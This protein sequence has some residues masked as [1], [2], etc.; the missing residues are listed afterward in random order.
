MNP[1]YREMI[2]GGELTPVSKLSAAFLSPRSALHLQF[3]YYESSLVVEFLVERFGFEALK[4]ILKDLREGVSIN[5][6]LARHTLNLQELDDRFD[7]FARTRAEQMAPGLDWTRPNDDGDALSRVFD[8]AALS[9]ALIE[10]SKTNSAAKSTN[11]SPGPRPNFYQLMEAAQTQLEAKQFEQAKGPLGQL[12]ELYP[13]QTGGD[14]AY[15]LLAAAHR[16]LGETK[17]ERE[18]L[19]KLAAQ[20]DSAREVYHRL[21]EL[22]AKDGDWPAVVQ[23]AQR[24]LAVNPLVPPP[25]RFLAQAAEETRNPMAAIRAYRALLQLD[26]SDP[27]ETHYRLARSLYQVK[28]PAARREVLEALEEAPRHPGALQLLLELHTRPLQPKDTSS[29][30]AQ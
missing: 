10:Q 7:Q 2:L 17:Q 20:D 11:G 21:M 25:Y 24:Y 14:S 23:N 29:D 12:I 18:V 8:A 13:Q 30:A 3:A 26:P 5:D 4:A 22:A 6:A 16:A 27:A 9:K 19:A 15:A 28:D 1:R